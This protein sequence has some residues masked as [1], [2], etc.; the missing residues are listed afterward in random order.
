MPAKI[1]AVFRLQ[2]HRPTVLES[3]DQGRIHIARQE[4]CNVWRAVTVFLP[5][6]R[7]VRVPA[8]C[9]KRVHA[10]FAEAAQKHL[11]Y[12][13]PILQVQHRRHD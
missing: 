5:F 10:M 13:A 8:T 9:G 7:R 6:S 1:G 12:V 2:N 11:V 3:Y 4:S